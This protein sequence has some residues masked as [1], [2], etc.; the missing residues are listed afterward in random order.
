MSG[1]EGWV[2]VAFTITARGTVTDAVVV[3]SK[4][5]RLFN[6]SALT[7]IR[8]WRFK[9]QVVDGKPVPVRATQVIEF[10]LASK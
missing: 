2:K 10:K 1:K 6:R 5:R 9:P 8:K 7:A 3:E 4:P